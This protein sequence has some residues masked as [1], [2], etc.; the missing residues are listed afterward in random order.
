MIYINIVTCHIHQI[1]D[2]HFMFVTRFS[3]FIHIIRLIVVVSGGITSNHRIC[4]YCQAT[5]IV[6]SRFMVYSFNI[7]RLFAYCAAV[8]GLNCIYWLVRHI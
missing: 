4:K 6:M 3:H 1:L 5:V 2:L 8:F 7:I